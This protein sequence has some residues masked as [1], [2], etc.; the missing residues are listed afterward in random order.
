MLYKPQLSQGLNLKKLTHQPIYL[1]K[2]EEI[3]QFVEENTPSFFEKN[4]E[5]LIKILLAFV[6]V[7]AI[8]YLIFWIAPKEFPSNSIISIEEGLSL[9]Q[10]TEHLKKENVIK[11]SF[12][13]KT[14]VYLSANQK[15]IDSGKYFFN[16][17]ENI[18]TI[19]FRTIRGKYGIDSTAV[20]LPEG[21]TV[22]EM[23]RIL[24]DKF[25]DFEGETFI[26]L[27]KRKEG[28]L[29]PD[30][31]EFLPDVGPREVI[32][33]MEDNFQVKIKELEN[34]IQESGKSIEDIII[35]A[36]LLEEE[37]RTQE[38]RET[39]SGILWKRIELGIP[40]QVDAVFIYINGKNTYQL[41]LEDLK[42]DS[43][44]N[45]Y[46]YKGLPIGPISNPGLSSIKAALNPKDSPYLFY[47][48][49]RD[50]NMH[51]AEDFEG[52]KKNKELYLN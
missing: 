41:S 45:T 39:I 43:P 27:A 22:T 11:S 13:F 24:E 1:Y 36:S 23:A 40:L 17:K 3:N 35:M 4:K 26:N 6:F 9:D 8:F 7:F 15:D 38:T 16:R 5:I 21:T 42:I 28:F 18:F 2:M 30:T 32:G 51:Y 31:Y 37:A 10:I 19:L 49:D 25:G 46:L 20:T 29:F 12:W 14:F 48:S 34:E 44:Y 33:A 52:H 50:G 47:L